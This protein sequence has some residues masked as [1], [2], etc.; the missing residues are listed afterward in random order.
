[1][2]LSTTQYQKRM[3]ILYH[4]PDI[5]DAYADCRC[6]DGGISIELIILEKPLMDD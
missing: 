4:L 1:M 3:H 5:V 2:Q 6:H